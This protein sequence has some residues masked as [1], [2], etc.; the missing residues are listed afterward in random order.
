MSKSWTV[1][2][3]GMLHELVYDIHFLD[4]HSFKILLP[5]PP[6]LQTQCVES[7]SA[8]QNCVKEKSLFREFICSLVFMGH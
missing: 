7:L 8:G 3:G 4:T 6:I 5:S 2:R 1:L